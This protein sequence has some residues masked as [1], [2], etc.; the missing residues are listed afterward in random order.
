MLHHLKAIVLHSVKYGESGIIAQV[1]SDL[2]GRQSFLIHG[3]RKKKSKISPYLFQ[4]LSLLDI[5]G[6]IKETRDIQH[7]K[8]L[9]ASVPL[10]QLHF[11]IRKSSIAL[12]LSEILNKTLRETDSNL[13]LFDYLS[14]AIQVLDITEKGVE[15]FHLIFLM[16]YTKFIGIY[17]R[18]NRDHININTE[19]SFSIFDLIKYS[20]SDTSEISID[21]KERRLLLNELIQYYK[22]HFEGLGKINSLEILHEIF[23]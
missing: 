8:E 23:S 1:F 15:N 3:V 12:F 14:Q 17:P 13:A 20:L 4:P 16:Q 11:D 22:Y 6:Y 18:D 19:Q 21:N 7:I 9:K 10:Q 2:F 5:V